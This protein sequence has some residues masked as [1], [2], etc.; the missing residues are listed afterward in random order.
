MPPPRS[1]VDQLPA[2]PLDVVGDIHG[3]YD[4]LVAL[5]EALGYDTDGRHAQGRTLVFVGD[6]C[7]RGPDSVQVMLLVEQLVR[8][9]AA[10]CI[11]GNHELNLLR[12]DAKDG[13]GW[14]FEARAPLDARYGP[15]RRPTDAQRARIIA[16]AR[17]LPLVLERP[18]LRVVHAAWQAESIALARSLGGERAHAVYECYHQQV[19]AALTADGR[20]QRYLQERERWQ[21]ALHD[22]DRSDIP[23]LHA[24]GDYDLANQLGNPIRVLSSGVERKGVAPFFSGQKWRFVDRV[25]WWD[26]YDDATPVLIGHYWRSAQA[27]ERQEPGKGGPSLFEGVAPFAWHGRRRNVFCLDYSV[28]GRWRQRQEGRAAD[29]RF[30]LAA[31][32]WPEREL[33]FD[34]GQRVATTDFG[35]EDRA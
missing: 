31:M 30:R 33:V 14:F 9:A 27:V 32:R 12:D 29:R 28:G 1:L 21:H 7:D 16:F 8:C 2:G 26:G 4:A 34:D 17:D 3:E 22:E 13:S 25:A 15:M 19:R 6:L 11:L 35:Q 10:R 18:D 24:I 20:R 5:L 23:Y